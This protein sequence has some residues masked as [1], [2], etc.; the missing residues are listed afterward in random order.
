MAKKG[1]VDGIGYPKVATWRLAGQIASFPLFMFISMCFSWRRGFGL[2]CRSAAAM[3]ALK[4]TTEPAALGRGTVWVRSG[5]V[6]VRRRFAHLSSTFH[7]TYLAHVLWFGYR[8]GNIHV[9][10]QIG[11][12]LG[13]R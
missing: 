1:S 2:R 9:L 4:R 11:Y 13:A 8:L 7:N 3:R 12:G 5:T 6:W 10:R